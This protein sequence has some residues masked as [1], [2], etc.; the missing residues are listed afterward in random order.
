MRKLL[1]EFKTAGIRSIVYFGG[2][3]PLM[4]KKINE[5]LKITHNLGIDYA[6]NTNGILLE[7]ASKVIA[8]SCSW[9]RISLDAASAKK[10]QELHDGKNY[11]NKIIKNIK[12]LNKIKK[13]TVGTS[14][15]VMESNVDE[16]FLAAKLVKDIGC[17]FIQFKPKYIPNPKNERFLN[18]YIKN[19]NVKIKKQLERAKKLEDANFSILVTGSMKTLLG[20]Q[21]VNQN[22]SYAYCAAQQFI[23]LVT[24]HGVYVCPNL[25]GAKKGRIGDISKN[26][27]KK[28]WTSEERKN[29]INNINPAKDC[30][31]ACLR[32][33]IN[34]V[35][36]GIID[37]EKMG[38][39][40][41]SLI[42]ETKGADISDRYF[43]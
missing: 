1:I 31:L 14:F 33:Q 26:S 19:L 18:K 32:H 25:R 5:I 29:I 9:I 2:G 22:K 23:P 39:D 15:V 43:I 37:N 12:N 30:T 28:I 3:E 10:Y 17:D 21:P 35:V 41:L 24:P 16:I 42:E 40:L 7:R 20:S 11:F 8:D 27:F 34:A 36:N 4:Y 38:V 6:I 13:G